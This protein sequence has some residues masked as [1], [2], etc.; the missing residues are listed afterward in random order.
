MVQEG[1]SAIRNDDFERLKRVVAT[2]FVSQKQGV[3]MSEMSAAANI[4][5]S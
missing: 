3:D 1:E 5:R 4:M 2:M